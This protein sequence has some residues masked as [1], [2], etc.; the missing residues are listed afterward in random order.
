MVHLKI[1]SQSPQHLRRKVILTNVLWVALIL[2]QCM[3][4]VLQILDAFNEKYKDHSKF[5]RYLNRAL[6]ILTEGFLIVEQWR[7]ILFFLKKKK[8]RNYCEGKS[9]SR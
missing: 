8:E 4:I 6:T 5:F 2:E 7:Y 1:M 3:S 9:F